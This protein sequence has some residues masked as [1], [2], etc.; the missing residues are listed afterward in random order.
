MGILDNL[1]NVLGGKK[2][3]SIASATKA[4]SQVLKENG[5]DPGKL[6]FSFA[7]DGTVT[8]SGQVAQDADLA[9]IKEL[10]LGMPG[11]KKVVQDLS[12]AATATAQQAEPA[13][14]PV[15]VT[16]PAAAQPSAS[17][18]PIGETPATTKTYTVE[19]GDTLW[20]IA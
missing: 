4:P 9:R 17:A 14:D 20:K 16:T 19:A 13:A 6:K 2:D 11:I 18:A 1:K 10:L 8:V 15:T 7:A 12:V 5:V 3:N